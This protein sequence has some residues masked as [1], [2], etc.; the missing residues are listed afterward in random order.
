MPAHPIAAGLNSEYFTIAQDE[1][2]GE[3]LKFHNLTSRYS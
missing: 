3:Y 1:T 2:Y